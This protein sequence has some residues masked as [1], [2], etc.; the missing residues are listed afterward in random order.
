MTPY[1]AA[2][3]FDSRI[4]DAGAAADWGA[5]SW[6]ATTPSGTAVAMS[7]RTRQHGEPDGTWTAFQP[8]A[9]SGGALSRNLSLY[10]VPRGAVDDEPAVTP[11]LESVTIGHAVVD[12]T[13]PT[14][15]VEQAAG[16]ADPTSASPV[17][18]HG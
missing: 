5:L 1:P 16:Q 12:T 15:T 13:G 4:F 3:T 2:G 14:V 8:V 18:F 11:S 17:H 6:T 7:Y 9:S 10:P